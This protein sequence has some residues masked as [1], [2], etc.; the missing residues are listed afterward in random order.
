MARKGI[1]MVISRPRSPEEEATYNTWY[2]EHH[3]PDSLL[4]P[5]FVKGR[6]FKLADTQLLP[7]R[8]TEPGFDYVAIYELDDIDLVPDAQ[9]LLPKVAEI[10][11]EFM[12][13]AM[14][15]DSVKAFIYEQ[16]FETTEPTPLPEGV[17]F[18]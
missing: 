15:P 18:G 12:S 16:I 7:G 10:S 4:L 2:D 6:R 5:G 3:V 1:F 14:D 17:E 9:A 13:A 11:G 8:A